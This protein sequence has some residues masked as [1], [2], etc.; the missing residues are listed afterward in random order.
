M[1]ALLQRGLKDVT[2]PEQTLQAVLT[3]L[4]G[5]ARGGRTNVPEEV[6]V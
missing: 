1:D 2:G 6:S 4:A 5:R 3:A